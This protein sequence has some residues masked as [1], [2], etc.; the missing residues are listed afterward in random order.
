MIA[1]LLAGWALA[2]LAGGVALAAR[3]GLHVRMEAV[4]RACHELRGPL[5][6]VRLGLSLTD[7]GAG[8]T[9]ARR[10]AIDTELGRAALAL[11]DLARVGRGGGTVAPA[12]LAQVSLARMVAEAVTAA[13]GRATAGGASVSGR[14]EGADAVLWGDRLRIAQ[15]LGNLL[16]NAAE[17]G[18]G[19]I[20]VTGT[21]REGRARITIDDDG[22]GLPAP[23]AALAARPRA[24]RGDRGRGLA[25]AFGIARAH[26]GTI[27]AAPAASGG[28][29]VL[30]LPARSAVPGRSPDRTRRS[31]A[32]R[33]ARGPR[34]PRATRG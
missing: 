14:W 11:D 1:V 17:H 29:V 26:G 16:V 30:S 5:T 6:A 21:L 9:S 18:G 8:L 12:A 10:D 20:R 24:G 3:H 28:R 31:A 4:A 27:T 2:L 32:D 33:P 25:I 13:E 7:S 23:V 34:L 22:P 19:R 15:A